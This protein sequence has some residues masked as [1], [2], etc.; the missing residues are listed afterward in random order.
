MGQGGISDDDSDIMFLFSPKNKCG[1][2]SS[3][4]APVLAKMPL[5]STNYA[6][7]YE[8]IIKKYFSLTSPLH[9]SLTNISCKILDL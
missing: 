8:E 3:L 7:F 2:Y 4:K 5:M 9:V 6:C 1:G